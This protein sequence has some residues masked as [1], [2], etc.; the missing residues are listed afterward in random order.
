M[1]LS[2]C[3]LGPVTV[4]EGGGRARLRQLST[5]CAQGTAKPSAQGG[6]WLHVPPVQIGAPGPDLGEKCQK[7][8]FILP[9]LPASSNPCLS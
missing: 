8:N 2:H 5:G 9:D 4:L 6:D 7:C 3:P 1:A